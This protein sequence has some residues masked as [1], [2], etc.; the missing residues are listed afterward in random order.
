[1]HTREFHK[2]SFFLL[3]YCPSLLLSLPFFHFIHQSTYACFFLLKLFKI[4]H[5]E[6][7]S[8]LQKR[9]QTS[10]KPQYNDQKQE[11]NIYQILLTH[12]L[13]LFRLYQLSHYCSFPG[14]GS[15]TG[16]ESCLLNVFQSR[17]VSQSFVTLTLLQTTGQ[18]FWR[19]SLN[20][21]NA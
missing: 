16:S 6:M 1:M 20:L 21:T 4:F 7:I 9:W 5:F 11:I 13:T 18:L 19:I 10:C 15:N 8:G 17:T 12:S 3:F 2:F 14:P